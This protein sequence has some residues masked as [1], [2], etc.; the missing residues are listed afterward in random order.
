MTNPVDYGTIRYSQKRDYWN[1]RR[2][3]GYPTASL[4]LKDETMKFKT[5]TGRNTVI[6]VKVEWTKGI[7]T[8]EKHVAKKKRRYA[9]KIEIKNFDF[10]EITA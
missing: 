1:P 10:G 3:R 9:H 7:D 2:V 8:L 5:V 4:F 6:P